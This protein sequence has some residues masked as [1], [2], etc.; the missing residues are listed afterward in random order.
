MDW[1]ALAGG[2]VSVLGLLNMLVS[3]RTK[4]DIAELKVSVLE[5]QTQSDKETRQ[6]AEDEFA[7]KET[8]QAQLEALKARR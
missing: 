4:A 1:P 6:W 7:R 2:I 8:V 5:R 3:L